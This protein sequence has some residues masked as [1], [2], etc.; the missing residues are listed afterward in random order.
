MKHRLW[1]AR[2][3]FGKDSMD[4]EFPWFCICQSGVNC[5]GRPLQNDFWLLPCLGGAPL[6][7]RAECQAIRILLALIRVHA[8]L[9]CEGGV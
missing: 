8:S 7:F 2:V 5:F 3:N 6:G 9:G 1:M 4:L